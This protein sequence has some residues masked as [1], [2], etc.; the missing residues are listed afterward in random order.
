[1]KV[2]FESVIDGINKYID[3]EI[4]SGLND[5]QEFAARLVV[6]RINSNQAVVKNF[7][8]NN[9][10]MKTLGIVDY[11]GMVDVE[12]LLSEIREEIERKGSLK[13]E[14]PLIGTLTF[15]SSDVDTLYR[16]ITGGE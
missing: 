3:K 14:I 1:M 15:K 4:Y 11:E 16:M 6:G 10:F 9:G 2:K 13:V 12:Q 8:M 5:L 7:L